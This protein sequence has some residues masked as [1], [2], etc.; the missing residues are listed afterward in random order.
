MALIGPFIRRLGPQLV[1]LI[2]KDE[3]V[4]CWRGEAYAAAEWGGYQ[5]PQLVTTV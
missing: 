5:S 4:W 3:E 2:G 1:G